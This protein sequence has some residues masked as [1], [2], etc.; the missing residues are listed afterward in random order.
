MNLELLGEIMNASYRH[1]HSFK[2]ACAVALGLGFGAAGCQGAAGGAG[3]ETAGQT[4]EATAAEGFVETWAVDRTVGVRFNRVTRPDDAAGPGCTS[5]VATNVEFYVVAIV[6]DREHANYS[7][8]LRTSVST[9]FGSGPGAT[10]HLDEAAFAREEVRAQGGSTNRLRVAAHPDFEIGRTCQG[11][12]QT[13]TQTATFAE[14]GRPTRE[15]VTRLSNVL[16][17]GPDSGL[18]PIQPCVTDAGAA[19]ASG[20]SVERCSGAPR[21]PRDFGYDE[22]KI[23][24][25]GS[26]HDG[27]GGVPGLLQGRSYSV[28]LSL[29]GEQRTFPLSCRR[30]VRFPSVTQACALDLV[31]EDK[32]VAFDDEGYVVDRG[33]FTFSRAPDRNT[34]NAWDVEFAFVDEQ[35]NWVKAD[36][37]GN[38][39]AR[40]E[41]RTFP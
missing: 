25:R 6:P 19:N 34:V 26:A 31:S 10:I 36:D 9:P 12:D 29:N 4:A 7:F 37:G 27:D 30:E 39:K 35:G 28:W 24:V 17:F 11:V 23:R 38:F 2:F 3:G 8:D 13:F 32:V 5:V 16:S 1:I 20:V 22:L 40:V 14:E 15:T 18:F 41:Q 21:D 33:P